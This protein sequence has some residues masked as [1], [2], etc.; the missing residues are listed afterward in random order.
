MVRRPTQ[1]PEPPKPGERISWN[2]YYEGEV[3]SW[4]GTVE[5]ESGEAAIALAAERF[6]YQP[7]KLM[8]IRR[9]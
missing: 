7:S 5:A 9:R 2:V 3:G 8:V 6:G 1:P 4:I